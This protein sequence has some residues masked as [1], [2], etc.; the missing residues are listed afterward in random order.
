MALWE[1][2]TMPGFETLRQQTQTVILPLG[3][4]EEHGPHLPLG[5]DTF[6]AIEVARRVG[7][8]RLVVV[9][10]PLFYGLCR[11]TREHPGTVSISGDALRTLLMSVGREFCRQGM[12][13]LV[14]ISGHAGGTHMSAILEAGEQLLAELPA[15]RVAVV[16]LLE[17]LREVVAEQPDLVH[18][19][20]DSHAGEVETA[21]MMAAY[22]DLV[23]G[24]APEEWPRFPKYEL[25]RNKRHYWPGGV[26]GNPAPATAAQGEAILAAEAERLSLVINALEESGDR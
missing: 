20:G 24:T 10:P 4:L 3:S 16:N 23:R 7:L 6:H 14:F 17:L 8:L 19:R 26:W 12:R 15:V 2:L 25:V 5:T 11:S 18:T 1:N 13:H 22:P 9:A 21:I